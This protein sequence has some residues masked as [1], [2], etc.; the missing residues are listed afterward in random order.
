MQT[1]LRPRLKD[2]RIVKFEMESRYKGTVASKLAHVECPGCT[3]AA[4]KPSPG[5]YRILD[6]RTRKRTNEQRRTVMCMVCGT[7]QKVIEREGRFIVEEEAVGTETE[8]RDSGEHPVLP[9]TEA[10]PKPPKPKGS[11]P[12]KK[13]KAKRPRKKKAN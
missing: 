13:R 6:T 12:P 7:S 4:E 5:K 9:D 3:K 1:T 10:D 8:G 2:H 11:K